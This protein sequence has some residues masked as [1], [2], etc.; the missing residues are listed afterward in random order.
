MSENDWEE[1]RSQIVQILN[2]VFVLDQDSFRQTA[3]ERGMTLEQLA[4]ETVT[5]HCR[6]QVE[7]LQTHPP[8]KSYCPLGTPGVS[9]KH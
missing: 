4:A 8:I 7:W 6:T 3:Q 9:P 2:R 5:E 1:I